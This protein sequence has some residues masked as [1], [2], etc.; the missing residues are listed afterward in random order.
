MATA[1]VY[2]ELIEELREGG[3][4]QVEKIPSDDEQSVSHLTRQERR[5]SVRRRTTGE[6]TLSWMDRLKG[7]KASPGRALDVTNEG[8]QLEL[9]AAVPE[10]VI[11]RLSGKTL[12]CVGSTRY[13]REVGGKYLVGIRLM[14]EPYPKEERGLHE[15]RLSCRLA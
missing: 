10:Q 4:V 11:V 5:R 13:C 12:E 1:E 6:C 3:V 7:R 2:T 8:L 9:A 14:G 15:V